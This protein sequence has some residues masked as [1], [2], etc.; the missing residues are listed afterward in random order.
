MHEG[1]T[2][3]GDTYTGHSRIPIAIQ[4]KGIQ[5]ISTYGITAHAM[6]HKGIGLRCV[7]H[8]FLGHVQDKA[9]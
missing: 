8:T 1:H 6:V 3:A 4:A 7:S 9:V 2:Y 5:V